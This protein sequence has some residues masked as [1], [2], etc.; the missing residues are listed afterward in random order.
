M[1]IVANPQQIQALLFGNFWDV[2]PPNIFD[3]QVAEF[4]DEEHADT[5]GQL[6]KPQIVYPFI[7]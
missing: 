6:Y 1:E 3:P 5:E 4:T 2:F 7:R